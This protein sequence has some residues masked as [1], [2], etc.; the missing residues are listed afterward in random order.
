MIY[1]GLGSNIGD[2]EAYLRRAVCLLRTCPG[3]RVSACSS[4]YE[5][6]PFGYTDQ[7]AFLNAVAA[8]ETELT[9]R[10]LLTACLET[11]RRLGRKRSLRWGPRTIDI[12]ILLFDELTVC[13]PDLVIP[14]SYLHLRPFVLVPLAE[15]TG[16]LPVLNGLTAAALLAQC[17]PA[18]VRFYQRFDCDGGEPG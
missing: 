14:H 10:Q 17:E 2:R 15:L 1:L 12:D 13:E 3:I 6:E 7:A 9:P 18:A 5:T 16:D 4:I 11:E 8:V